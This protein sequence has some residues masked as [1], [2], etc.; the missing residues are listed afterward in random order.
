MS[1]TWRD[2]MENAPRDGTTFLA[3]FPLSDLGEDWVRGLPVY[4]HD[5]QERWN[6]SGP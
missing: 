1:I 6:F 4:W 2:D 5:K 3:W